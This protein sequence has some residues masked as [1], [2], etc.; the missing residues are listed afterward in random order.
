[1]CRGCLEAALEAHPRSAAASEREHTALSNPK[2]RRSSFRSI[3][4]EKE[5]GETT[6]KGDWNGGGMS[7]VMRWGKV[8]PI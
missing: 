3:E 1:M 7:I 4:T 8:K 5:K 2:R 6:T